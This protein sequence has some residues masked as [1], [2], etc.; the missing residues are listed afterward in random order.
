MPYDEDED[1]ELVLPVKFRFESGWSDETTAAIF[2]CIIKHCVLLAEF[3]H[4]RGKMASGSFLPDNVPTYKF[5]NPSFV[6]RQFSLGQLPPWLFFRNILKPREG[7]SEMMEASRVF[8]LGLDLPSL[9]LY[10]WTRA[11][12]SLNLFDSWWKEWHSHLFCSPIH[13]NCLALDEEFASDS[14]IIYY[15]S[16]RRII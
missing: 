11:T 12:F 3:C 9:C 6:V 14:E 16:F 15:F 13:P 8:Q 4:G 7:I 1:N 5:Y 10:E 2:S